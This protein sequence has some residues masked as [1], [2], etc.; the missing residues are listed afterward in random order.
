[1]IKI[2][3]LTTSEIY[4]NYC[5]S[6][7]FATVPD[8][9]SAKMRALVCLVFIALAY[10]IQGAPSPYIIGGKDAPIGKFPY[11]VSLRYYGVYKCGGSILNNYNILTAASCVAG[12]ENRVNNLKVHVGT[13]FLNITG[14]A[15]DVAS[16]SIHVNHLTGNDIALVHLK[17]PL[18]YSTLVQPINL[19]TSDENLD[20]KSCTLSGWGKKNDRE[21]SNNL[22]EIELRVY[23]QEKCRR[24]WAVKNTQLC[25]LTSEGE[26]ACYG[27]QGSPLVANGVQI[28]IVSFGNPCALGYP[29]VYTRV[30]SFVSWINGHLRN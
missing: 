5:V 1:M 13:N 20:G 3:I 24:L 17:T 9:K 16:V 15:Y 23:P 29:D 21:I 11:Q 8:I 27:D 26:G 14:A 4:I 30:S 6:H 18:T 10:A 7:L 2:F 19:M 12:L 22:Q 25:T 28:G